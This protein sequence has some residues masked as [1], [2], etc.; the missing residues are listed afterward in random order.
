MPRL[1]LSPQEC[2]ELFH[3]VSNLLTEDPAIQQ[4]EL[5]MA[6]GADFKL[7]EQ[8]DVEKQGSPIP[9][10]PSPLLPYSNP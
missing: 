7:F 8:L 1:T 4:E 3:M 9:P 2:E 5:V 6:Q 10:S